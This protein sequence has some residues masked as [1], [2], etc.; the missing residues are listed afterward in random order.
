MDSVQSWF[1][2]A[3]DLL[4]VVISPTAIMIAWVISRCIYV[5]RVQRNAGIVQA[6]YAP[7]VPN[8]PGVRLGS[9]VFALVAS[10]GRW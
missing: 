2:A 6:R 3:V 4:L 8:A 10:L 5:R 9:F 1:V 7:G